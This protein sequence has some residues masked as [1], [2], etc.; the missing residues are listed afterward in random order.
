MHPSA[1][2]RSVHRQLWI[3]DNSGDARPGAPVSGVERSAQGRCAPWRTPGT[4]L[5]RHRRAKI[6]P[7]HALVAER[8]TA[9]TLLSGVDHHGASPAR[10]GDRCLAHGSARRLLA[11]GR[12][13]RAPRSGEDQGAGAGAWA[14]VCRPGELSDGHCGCVSHLCSGLPR[15]HEIADRRVRVNNRCTPD[16]G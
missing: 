16:P 9:G 6:T 3:D 11:P 13:L 4:P 10:G 1:L 12:I 14:K 5:A 15:R 8:R 2:D 7:S